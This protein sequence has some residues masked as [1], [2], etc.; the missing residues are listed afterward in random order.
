MFVISLTYKKPISEIELLINAHN[1]FL[2]K[3]YAEKIFLASGRKNP[4]T[5]GI[6]LAHNIGLEDLQNRIKEDPFYQNGVADYE[7]I[8]FVATKFDRELQNFFQN[9]Q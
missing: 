2:D 8:E 1:A 9:H 3:N 6:I 4:R 5:G 7:I